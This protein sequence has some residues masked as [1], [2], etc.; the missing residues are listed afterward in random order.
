MSLLSRNLDLFDPL[1]A[2]IGEQET[3]TGQ[4]QV[5]REH[6]ESCQLC[7]LHR[8]R[9]KAVPGEGDTTSGLMIVGEGPGENEDIRGVPFVGK[10]GEL[11]DRILAAAE[12]PRETVFIT[13]IVK[14]RAS[15]LVD[16]RQQNRAPHASEAGA[17]RPYLVRQIE[18]IQPRVILCLGAPAAR[19]VIDPGFNITEQRGRLFDGPFGSHLTATFH[20]AFILR[21]GGAGSGAKELKRLVWADIQQVRDLLAQAQS[22]G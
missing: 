8:N 21:R 12:I 2:A 10:A 19:G 18:I 6:I 4:L 3:M 14:C 15:E 7:P 9:R 17:C 16:G 5:L 13:N 22:S 20:P 11:L 1:D